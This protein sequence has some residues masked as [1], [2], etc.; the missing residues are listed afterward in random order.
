MRETP[1]ART[2]TQPLVDE[3]RSIFAVAQL[4]P[5]GRL[6]RINIPCL[7]IQYQHPFTNDTKHRVAKSKERSQF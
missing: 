4:L 1:F 7:L 5:E 3:G 6:P 2:K